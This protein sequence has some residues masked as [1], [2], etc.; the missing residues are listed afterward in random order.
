MRS[1]CAS[2][3]GL[4]WRAALC[5]LCLVGGKGSVDLSLLITSL[6]LRNNCR[7]VV[8]QMHRGGSLRWRIRRHRCIPATATITGL[9]GRQ[10]MP[11]PTGASYTVKRGGSWI[12][13]HLPDC[14]T[15]FLH[16]DLTHLQQHKL[17]LKECHGG[18]WDTPIG[19]ISGRLL[20]VLHKHA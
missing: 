12:L 3:Y 11:H 6:P 8:L 7:C 17:V 4:G 1:V 10:V 14:I 13:A 16:A 2:S 5:E 18:Q 19:L 9:L 20:I 15:T